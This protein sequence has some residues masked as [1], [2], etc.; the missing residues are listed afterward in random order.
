MRM[1]SLI[2]VDVAVLH[3]TEAAYLVTTD[4][5]NKI[6]VPKSQCE[7]VDD[8]GEPT[9]MELEEKLAIEKGLI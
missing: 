3:Q 5:E 8:S 4:G 7:V 9:I 1:H 6:W 2:E